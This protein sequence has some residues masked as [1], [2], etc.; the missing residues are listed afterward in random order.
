MHWL[1]DRRWHASA[2]DRIAVRGWSESQPMCFYSGTG[3]RSAL[4]TR[5][6]LVQPGLICYGT[7]RASATC[8]CCNYRRF[9]SVTAHVP[10]VGPEVLCIYASPVVT[11]ICCMFRGGMHP[12]FVRGMGAGSVAGPAVAGRHRLQV[13]AV[14]EAV[15]AVSG[16]VVGCGVRVR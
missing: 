7:H 12:L 16:F 11:C 2:I 5:S 10:A 3:R 9:R 13:V 14:F 1:Y 6:R 8:V 4:L 15:L